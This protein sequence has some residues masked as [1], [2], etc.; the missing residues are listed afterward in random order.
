MKLLRI[1][2]NVLLACIV[3]AIVTLGFPLAGSAQCPDAFCDYPTEDPI[4]CPDDC[5]PDITCPDMTCDPWENAI[6][7]A[8]DCGVGGCPDFFCDYPM[9]TPLTCPLD[10]PPTIVCGNSVCEEWESVPICS[11]D[12]LVDS[13]GDGLYDH[14]EN[15]TYF[16]DPANPDTDGDGINDGDEVLTHTTNPLDWDTDGDYLPDKYEVDNASGHS[17][18]EDLDPL[19]VTDGSSDFDADDNTN[20]HEY[21][22]N[23]DPWA[24][25]PVPDPFLSPGCF[26]WG[27]G[28]GDGV[29]GPGDINIIQ[30]EVAGIS[31]AYDSVLAQG[32]FD[33]Q[34]IDKDGVP[35]PGD[36]ALLDIMVT[37]GSRPAGY[38]SSPDALSVVYQPGSTVEV[39]STTHVTLSVSNVAGAVANSTGFSVVF[40][41][42]GGSAT[43]LGGEGVAF[44]ETAGNRYDMSGESSSGAQSTV[45]LEV[46]GSGT[47]TIGAKIPACGTEPNGRWCPEILLAPSIEITTD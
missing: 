13:D 12:C 42:E 30:Q 10:C 22:N 44:G 37:Q 47:I 7:C 34:D 39:G 36:K 8:A 24:A 27:E 5:P 40:W 20:A 28:D 11:A 16:T 29:P 32:L 2:S 6:T 25:E 33:T 14:E 19:N 18:G 1:L 26:Y 23:S 21:W 35:G 43:L 46:D 15:E 4:N 9:E 45:V 38:E 31:Q 41:V 3:I 17:V